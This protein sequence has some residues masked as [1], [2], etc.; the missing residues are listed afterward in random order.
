[1]SFYNVE[2][3]SL[4]NID[5]I[6]RIVVQ[7]STKLTTQNVGCDLIVPVWWYRW[8]E[9]RQMDSNPH[10]TDSLSLTRLE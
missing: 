1:M 8:T 7:R 3:L 9:A 4:F 2:Q 6:L 10:E 5:I